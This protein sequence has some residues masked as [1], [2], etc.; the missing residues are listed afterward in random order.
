MTRKEMKLFRVF[1]KIMDG[2]ITRAAAAK[3]LE[4]SERQVNRLMLAHGVERPVQP[5][6][7]ARRGR[8]LYAR[9]QRENRERAARAFM[10][11][12]CSV[13]Q[14]ALQ[15]GSSVRTVYRWAAKLK[16]TGKKIGK[17]AKKDTKRR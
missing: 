16:K 6:A 2:K 9:A 5:R 8:R 3:R 14:A 1:V 4:V 12:Q 11:E 10:A 15:C 7:D 13:E 17:N